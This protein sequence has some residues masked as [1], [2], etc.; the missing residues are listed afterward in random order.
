VTSR[1]RIVQ[2]TDSAA[3]HSLTPPLAA[4]LTAPMDFEMSGSGLESR[5][6]IIGGIEPRA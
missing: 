6:Q 3:S 4:G 5:V 2:D 1:W